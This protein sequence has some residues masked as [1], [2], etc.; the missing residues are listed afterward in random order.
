[1]KVSFT[2]FT[3]ENYAQ[4][5]V[6][7]KNVLT[8]D[9]GS[10]G[11]YLIVR[12]LVGYTINLSEKYEDVLNNVNISEL[13]SG[14]EVKIDENLYITLFS[15]NTIVKQFN[16][17]VCPAAYAVY[18]CKYDSEADMMQIYIPANMIYQTSAISEVGYKISKLVVKK[19]L[20]QRVGEG[21]KGVFGMKKDEP[22]TY[23]I[24]I[25]SISAYENG[26]YYGFNGCSFKFPVTKDML[27]QT[28]K[29][30][31]YNEE[32]P[33]VRAYNSQEYIVKQER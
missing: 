14:R 16:I 6:V 11:D 17:T 1:M 7:N 10:S 2:N 24:K 27:G 30:I 21:V 20:V 9:C 8:W 25:D 13:Y 29:V 5:P 22:L 12:G 19:S 28:F 32:E 23:K 18:C 26:L 31:A 33:F 15:G 4:N 3:K